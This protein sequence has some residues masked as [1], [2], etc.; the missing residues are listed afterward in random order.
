MDLPTI[1][2]RL[3]ALRARAGYSQEELAK[4][5]GFSD[6]Q[7]Y[8]QIEL[9]ERKIKPEELVRAAKVF[10]VAVDFF[11]N[12][13]ELAGEGVFSWRQKKA[14]GGDLDAYES[15]AGTWIAAFRHL[16]RLK[17]DSI[18]SA[19]HR[20]ALT[21]K[22]T[23]SEAAAEGS[24]ISAVLELG[25]IP[26]QRLLSTLEQTLSTLVLHVDMMPGVSGAACQLQ[27]LNTIFIN[28][29][30]SEGRRA[31][32]AAHEFFHLLTWQVM[33]PARID[34][35][36][37]T[38]RRQKH[39]EMLAESFAAGLLMP[40]RVIDLHLS[41]SPLPEDGDAALPK[42]IVELAHTLGVSADALAWRLVNLKKL[43]K[44]VV[45]QLVEVKA[46][47]AVSVYTKNRPIAK[48]PARFSKRFVETLG[49]GIE[50]GH[51]SVRRSATLLDTTV[52]DLATLFSEHGLKTPFDL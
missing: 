2:F 26:S 39:I 34:T 49:W 19:I 52:D 18:N 42:H 30:E 23:L 33:P 8:S 15:R 41:R 14:L 46:F 38:D 21:S 9:G 37:P 47:S 10:N 17:G 12:P 11:T 35:S 43:K 6:R 1:S 28:R 7:T 36:N 29:N 13:F 27:Q 48:P 40:S 32:D 50:N 16:S 51:L 22:S 44:A 31:F 3:N 5:L 24:A 45:K 25:D 4:K 20:I